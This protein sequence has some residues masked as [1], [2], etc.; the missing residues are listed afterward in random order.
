MK[1][2]GT[3]TRKRTELATWK[4]GDKTLPHLEKEKKTRI[5]FY[6]FVKPIAE[7]AGGGGGGG[8][9]GGGGKTRSHRLPG[10]KEE[11]TVAGKIR[12]V[13][14]SMRCKITGSKRPGKRLGRGKEE[15]SARKKPP[16]IWKR[17][18]IDRLGWL[19]PLEKREGNTKKNEHS[20]RVMGGKKKEGRRDVVEWCN[21]NPA[22]LPA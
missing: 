15:S 3:S 2:Q 21:E 13:A 17:E 6:Q 7:T 8:G 11:L 14:H 18:I 10:E 20:T 12:V 1:G 9:W 5:V 22:A 16:V 4:K 19:K